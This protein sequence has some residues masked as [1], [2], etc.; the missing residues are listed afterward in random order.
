MPACLP[1]SSPT[2][3]T[4]R[5]KPTAFT[6]CTRAEALRYCG[7]DPAL[8]HC[9][10]PGSPT[11][12]PPG[13]PSDRRIRTPREG[14][15]L[16]PTWCADRLADGG[17]GGL[18]GSAG[19]HRSTCLNRSTALGVNDLCGGCRLYGAAGTGRDSLGRITAREAF[20]GA[21]Y[22]EYTD[23]VRSD[24]ALRSA[25]FFLAVQRFR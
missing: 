24:G 20:E 13:G 19:T 14:P 25:S 16:I 15:A 17:G 2:L 7:P 3:P 1:H 4:H 21:H 11:N 6:V 18:T 5:Q 12:H 8:Y 10:H 9:W 22:F 23:D